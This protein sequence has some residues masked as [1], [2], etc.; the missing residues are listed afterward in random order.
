MRDNDTFNIFAWWSTDRKP[1]VAVF[2]CAGFDVKPQGPD[3]DR[4]IANATVSALTGF[5]GGLD[6]HEKGSK[7]CPLYYNGERDVRYVSGRPKF[8]P[9]CRRLV[10][11]SP[12]G[13]ALP[14]LEALLKVFS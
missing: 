5:F 7:D 6:A 12:L 2:S 8:D 13:D 1:P 9:G 14:A 11:R 4:A 10:R 3:T